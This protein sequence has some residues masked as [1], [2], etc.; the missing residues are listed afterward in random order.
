V[1]GDLHGRSAAP[2]LVDWLEQ[3]F[4]DEGLKVCRNS[5]YA[6][7]HTTERHGRPVDGLHCVQLEFDRT[8]YMEMGSLAP[9]TGFARLSAMIARVVVRLARTVPLPGLGQRLPLAA[10]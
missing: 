4:A 10:E 5:P 6:G 2:A 7:G 3:A 8:L 1:L 9:T